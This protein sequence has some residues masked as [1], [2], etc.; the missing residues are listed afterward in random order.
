MAELYRGDGPACGEPC[1]V[2]VEATGLRVKTESSERFLPYAKL[3]GRLGGY[4]DRWMIFT[5]IGGAGLELWVDPELLDTLKDNADDYPRAFRK[6]LF[7]LEIQ[8]MTRARVRIALRVVAAAFVVGAAVWFLRGDLVPRLVDV[9][10]VAVETG[11]G[12]VAAE[13]LAE[14]YEVC[15]DEE[16]VGAVSEVLQRLVNSG[17]TAGYSFRV[18]ILKSSGVNAFALPGGELFLLSGLLSLANDI[19]EVAAVLGHEVQ[20][21]LSRHGLA[22]LVRRAGVRASVGMALGDASDVLQVLGAYAGSLV[23]MKY[24]REQEEEADRGGVVRMAGAG[25]DPEASIRFFGRLA[26]EQPDGGGALREAKALFS[27]HPTSQRRRSKLEAHVWELSHTP[28]TASRVD[29]AR[30]RNR[31]DPAVGAEL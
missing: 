21:V 13:A 8:Q 11:L 1:E 28:S 23:T 27:T 25:F 18:R 31:C 16:L 6:Q 22:G 9:V 7:S 12:E 20:H 14:D 24:G 26:E 29:W 30:I 19:D 5:M 2:Q 4:D 3:R 10:P 17:E 15:R